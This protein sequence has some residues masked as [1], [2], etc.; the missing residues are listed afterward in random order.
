MV[1]LTIGKALKKLPA[2][3]RS[4]EGRR[5]DRTTTD[6]RD[7]LPGEPPSEEGQHQK[8]CERKCWDKPK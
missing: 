4:G 3:K 6:P 5:A 1:G 8:A 7:L 2:D